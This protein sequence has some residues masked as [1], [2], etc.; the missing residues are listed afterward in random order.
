MNLMSRS[1]RALETLTDEQE[2]RL[3]F[4][5]TFAVVLV[6]ASALRLFRSLPGTSRPG[7]DRLSLFAEAKATV[8]SSLA[9]AFMG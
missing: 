2:Y 6:A 4:V 8:N 1:H 5:V 7:G 9:F 3:L